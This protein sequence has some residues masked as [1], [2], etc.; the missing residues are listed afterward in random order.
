MREMREFLM[1]RAAFTGANFDYKDRSYIDICDYVLDR[2][3]PQPASASLTEEQYEYLMRCVAGRP[4]VSKQCFHN[5]QMLLTND[6]EGRLQYKEGFAF[7]GAIP[8]HHAWVE[9]DGKLVDVTRST[10]KEAV[11]EFLDGVE[12]Q[13]DLRDRVLGVVPAGWVYLGCSFDADPIIDR[14]L[15]RGETRCV[16][17]NWQ[18]R[19]PE[20]H[21]ERLNPIS[22]ELNALIDQMKQFQGA[23]SQR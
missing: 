16:L 2:G 18:D 17:D 11:Q 9:L 8:V 3:T 23:V 21:E 7:T 1:Q 13:S 22:P 19:Y 20:L 10:R 6:R 15:E 14:I 12:P 4:M 5:A